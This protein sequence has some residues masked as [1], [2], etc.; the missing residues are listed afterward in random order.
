MLNLFASKGISMNDN[1]FV[2]QAN[3]SICQQNTVI[4]DKIDEIMQSVMADPDIRERSDWEQIQK[5]LS[6]IISAMEADAADD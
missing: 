4:S 1:G 5:T 2:A 3:D 6:T